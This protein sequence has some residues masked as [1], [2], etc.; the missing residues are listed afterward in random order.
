MSEIQFNVF[1]TYI[2]AFFNISPVDFFTGLF[3]LEGQNSIGVNKKW[4]PQFVTCS[5]QISIEFHVSY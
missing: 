3:Y 1:Y 4:H 2:S 5:L